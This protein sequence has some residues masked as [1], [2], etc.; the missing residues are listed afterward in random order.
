MVMKEA[1][2]SESLQE[3][4]LIVTGEVQGVGYRQYVAKIGRKLKLVGFVENLNDGTVR[5]QC[6]GDKKDISGF[7]KQISRK[8]PSEAPLV[9]VEDV[10]EKPLKQGEIEQ[11]YFEEKYGELS[12]EMSQGNATG[13]NY[14]N[15]FRKDTIKSFKRIDKK[16]DRISQAMY[17]VVEEIEE[18][19]KTF[20]SRMEKTEKS[21]ES[22]LKILVEKS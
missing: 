19:N 7:K 1:V 18:R 16:Y 10:N 15:L 21:I 5:I 3:V 11:T 6:K 2:M 4:E 9:R 8:K 20:E 12:A 17:A 22:L 13:M 14:L